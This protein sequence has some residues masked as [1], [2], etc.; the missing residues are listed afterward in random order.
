MSPEQ[1]MIPVDAHL[2]ADE[3]RIIRILDHHHGRHSPIKLYDLAAATGLLPRTVQALI[4]DLI[5]HR[6]YPIG[7]SSREPAGK[8]EIP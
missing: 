4:V 7:S 8:A 2:S 5:V 6:R 3:A 1:L